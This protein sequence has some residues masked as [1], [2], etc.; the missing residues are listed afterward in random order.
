LAVEGLDGDDFDGGV[1]L[2]VDLP[3]ELLDV[4]FGGGVDHA[5]EVSNVAGGFGEFVGRFG[6]RK[7]GREDAEQ[8][9]RGESPQNV[10][11]MILRSAG[12]ESSGLYSVV[13]RRR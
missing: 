1:G 8:K 5:C 2:G 13:W 3:G 7:G 4:F 9:E 10:H 6:A 11:S 12:A